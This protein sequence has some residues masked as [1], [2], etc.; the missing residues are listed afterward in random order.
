LPRCSLAVLGGGLADVEEC[1]IRRV[2]N[3]HFPRPV[4]G[5]E[6]DVTAQYKLSRVR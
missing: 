4:G 1:V 5:G 6:V 3:V 2:K